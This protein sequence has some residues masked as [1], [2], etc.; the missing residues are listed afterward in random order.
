[1]ALTPYVRVVYQNGQA[2]A[3]N[4][5]NLNNNEQGTKAVTDQT[6]ANESAITSL[7]AQVS[8]NT[9]AINIIETPDY[10]DFTPQSLPPA[11]SEGLLY[12]D[13]TARTLVSYNDLSDTALN[14]GLENR[15]RVYNNSGS[16]MLNGTA[17]RIGNTAIDGVP[18]AI[19]SV[20]DNFLDGVCEGVLT[21]DLLDNAIGEATINGTVMGLDTSSFSVGDTLYL[22]ATVPGGITSTPPD[23]STKIGTVLISDATTGS[24]LVMINS[25]KTLPVTIGTMDTL[26]DPAQVSVTSTPQKF[27]NYINT[28]SLEMI[29][30]GTGGLITVKYDGSYNID[31]L[32][33]IENING[34]NNQHQIDIYARVNESAT[35]E[36]YFPLIVGRNGT[37][38]SGTPFTDLNLNAGDTVSMWYASEDIN[39]TVAVRSISFKITSNYI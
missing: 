17:I 5:T 15:V 19:L 6:I 35:N 28:K 1:M 27:Q 39:D 38:T 29:V 8:S 32:F 7:S 11:Y 9:D 33:V 37:R 36:F 26:V 2:P 20:A 30:D 16:T 24:I 4:A 34:S 21:H 23:L 14:I 25:L 3:R 18:V 13:M 31:T 22:S 10:I 12:Y